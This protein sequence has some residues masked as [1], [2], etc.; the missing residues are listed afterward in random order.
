MMQHVRAMGDTLNR[1]LLIP[2]VILSLLMPACM[3]KIPG[4]NQMKPEYYPQCYQPFA[5]LEKAQDE[6]I[7]RTVIGAGVGA[8]GGAALG[9]LKTGDA[10]G[11][12]IGGG[13]GLIAG[14]TLGY[15]FGK[16]KQIQDDRE[17]M[18]SYQADMNADM[19]N[20]SRVE[21]YAMASLQCY[22]REFNS[23]LSQ[24]KA[25][26]ITKAEMQA[27]YTEIRRGMNYISEI[28]ANSKN[29]LLKRDGEY[30]EAFEAEAKAKNKTAPKI[31]SMEKKR[32]RT[33]KRQ[34][35]NKPKRNGGNELSQMTAEVNR[36]KIQ[37]ERK[38][39]KVE[40]LEAAQVAVAE[41]KRGTSNINNISTYY[42]KQYL[43]SI[44]SLEEAE[45][46][47]QRTLTAMS[48]AAQHA[49]IDMV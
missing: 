25:G 27:R 14:T 18:R 20:A 5:D 4:L 41:K 31:I 36:R 29:E 7:K 16:M 44:M 28:L 9:F 3:P 42:E 43:D 13:A 1:F 21:Q 6:L 47:N 33:A 22:T 12:L 10:K 49:G 19:R 17:R 40:Q 11:A 15:G 2:L 37:A 46:L 38:V 45:S 48:V 26:Q 30:R 8:L 32:E 34:P 24:Y 39:Q 35:S 23:L